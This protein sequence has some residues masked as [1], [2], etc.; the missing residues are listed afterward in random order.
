VN[1]QTAIQVAAHACDRLQASDPHQTLSDMKTKVAEAIR[2]GATY[3]DIAV[4][5]TPQQP[6]GTNATVA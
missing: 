6:S 4:A 1:T 3:N 2:A 5:R